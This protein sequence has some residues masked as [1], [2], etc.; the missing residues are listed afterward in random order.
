MITFR[1]LKGL[2]NFVTGL[3]VAKN[4]YWEWE[5]AIF[6][7]ARIYHG[8]RTHGQ[9]TIQIDVE[10]R[11]IEFS[12]EVSIDLKGVTVGLGIGMCSISPSVGP[13][14][15]RTIAAQLAVCNALN[16]ESQDRDQ[17]VVKLVN[18]R[19]AC[20]AANGIAQEKIWSLNAIAYQLAFKALDDR[21]ECTAIALADVMDVK[22]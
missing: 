19:R 10:K 1:F 8:L 12:P 16:L 9:G 21:I 7:G 13:E 2:Q 18:E 15:A 14:A 3:E 20:V 11:T 6:D 5:N 17:I 22:N 4:Q